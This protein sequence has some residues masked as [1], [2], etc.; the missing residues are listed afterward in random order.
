MYINNEI[1]ED[2]EGCPVPKSTTDGSAPA[3]INGTCALGN[4]PSYVVNATSTDDVQAAVKFAARYNLRLRVKNSGHD[5]SGRSSG[6]GALS[7]WTRHL[8]DAVLIEGFVVEGCED[9]PSDVVSA[10]PGVNVEELNQW[11]ADNSRVTI[12]GYTPSVG[13]TGG[14]LLGGGFG[15]TAPHFGMGVDSEFSY[16]FKFA[17]QKLMLL[18][19]SSNLRLSLQMVRRRSR[20]R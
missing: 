15:P 3:P 9:A 10:G 7:I 11:G 5:Y 17:P 19:M 8:N 14:Y 16:N 1:T 13:A 4:M 20:T 12:G 18:K 6:E 2:G